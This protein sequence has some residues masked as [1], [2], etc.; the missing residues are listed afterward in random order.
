MAFTA[1]LPEDLRA[2]VADIDQRL[3][4]ALDGREPA[5]AEDGH[6]SHNES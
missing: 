1:P 4:D 2:V 6:A 5:D 3:L